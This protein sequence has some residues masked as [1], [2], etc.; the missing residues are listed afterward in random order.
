MCQCTDG[1]IATPN[2]LG[3]GI[4]APCGNQ[5]KSSDSLLFTLTKVRF[6]LRKKGCISRC[7]SQPATA[8]FAAVRIGL[9]FLIQVAQVEY[10]GQPGKARQTRILEPKVRTENFK[11]MRTE[12]LKFRSN[13]SLRTDLQDRI[14]DG[15]S[16]T[17]YMI[18]YKGRLLKKSPNR[19]LKLV[20]ST[21][22]TAWLSNITFHLLQSWLQI[23]V[24]IDSEP[25]QTSFPSFCAPPSEVEV[26]FDLNLTPFPWTGRRFRSDALQR[27]RFRTYS[28]VPKSYFYST[29]SK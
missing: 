20:L 2:G 5:P 21:Q 28:L 8:F 14:M 23:L 25:R 3:T 1:L 24:A 7:M 17:K 11:K 10:Q 29:N 27:I 19:K 18:V 12:N 16:V 4:S 22:V 6:N 9:S 15:W 26:L 13:F